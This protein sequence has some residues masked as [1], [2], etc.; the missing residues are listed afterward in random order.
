MALMRREQAP[1]S[2]RGREWEPL[3]MI[4]DL[5]RWDRLQELAPRLWRE[6][7]MPTVSPAFD[8]RETKDAYEFRADLPGFREQ[9][10]EV[11]LTSNRLTVSGKRE[12]EKIEDTEAHYCSERA[13]GS[14]TRTF[15][16][17]A[18]IKPDEVSAELHDGVLTIHV[19][20][21]TASQAK[22]IPVGGQGAQKAK[23]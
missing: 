5:L 11:N 13:F 20:K 8:V 12:E 6:E 21:T 3:E 16:M 10:I 18:D 2:I 9:D 22:R 19:P 1:M 15:T 4:R 7:R 14:F 23:A 17:P